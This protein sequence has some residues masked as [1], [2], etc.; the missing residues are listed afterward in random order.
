MSELLTNKILDPGVV[1]RTSINYPALSRASDYKLP[2][3]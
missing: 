3:S 1:Q 2:T